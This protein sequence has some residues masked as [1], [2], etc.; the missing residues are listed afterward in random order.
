MPSK[1]PTAAL[2]ELIIAPSATFW[3]ESE[4]GA[5]AGEQVVGHESVSGLPSRYNFQDVPS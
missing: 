2:D 4:R 1:R 3:I 5:A